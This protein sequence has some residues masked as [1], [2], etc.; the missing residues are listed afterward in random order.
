MSA[1]SQFRLIT[2]YGAIFALAGVAIL[3][4][5]GFFVSAYQ[6]RLFQAQRLREVTVQAQIL[7]ASVTAPVAFGGRGGGARI[8]QR[9]SGQSG[10]RVGRR[11]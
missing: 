10:D 9:A 3:L 2:R 1:Q 8:C 11:L 6:D 4:V 5:A 7:A